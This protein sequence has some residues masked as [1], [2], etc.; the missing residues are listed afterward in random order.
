M[1]SRCPSL[2]ATSSGVSLSLVTTPIIVVY[3]IVSLLTRGWAAAVGYSSW[4][5]CLFCDSEFV[6]LDVKVYVYSVD[7]LS[8]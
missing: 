5:V 4:S 8:Y 7:S 6:Y 2:A 1:V 3:Q